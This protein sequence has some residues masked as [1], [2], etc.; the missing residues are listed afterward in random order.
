[1]DYKVRRKTILVKI[2]EFAEK[3]DTMK[4]MI[5][6]GKTFVITKE[7][8]PIAEVLPLRGKKQNWKRKI[9]K[10]TLPGR[11]S[12]QSFVEEERKLR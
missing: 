4:S 11:V 5:E 1:M 10:V 6:N 12:A 2:N 3:V 8:E 9:E 7:G